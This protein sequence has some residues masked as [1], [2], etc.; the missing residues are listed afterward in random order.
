MLTS[1]TEN[2]TAVRLFSNP[3]F[4]SV[5]TAGSADNP[6]FCLA[7]ICK[8]LDL[9]P[10]KVAQR[11]EKDVL[12]RYTL[13][14][15]GGEQLMNFVNED[16]LYDVILDSRKPEAKAFRKWIT[17]DV[18]PTI[19]KTGGY[20][21]TDETDTDADI[22]AKA[23]LIAQRTIDAKQ[24]RILELDTQ[25]QLLAEAN[26]RLSSENK[27]LAPKAQY[28]DDVL[29]S[30]E[31]ATFTQMA[32]ELNFRSVQ[33]FIAQLTQDRIIFKQSGQ[34]LLTARYAGRG[35][36]RARV[37]RFFHT[38]GS[39][40]TSTSTVWTQAGRQFLASRYNSKN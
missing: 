17:S 28:T 15:A 1:P 29:L 34:Y 21:T 23:L 3:T 27:E 10:S 6:L 33:A 18:L 26:N 20:I 5:R 39:V 12:S 2:S 4:G 8:A 32:K 7:D 30:K 37:A 11:L 9:T 25:V 31:C 22:M 38:D 16:G 24:E 35:Y 40:G 36:T 19:R 14:T 13:E